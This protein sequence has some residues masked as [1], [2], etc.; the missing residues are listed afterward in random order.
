MEIL[1]FDTSVWIDF[2]KG[3]NSNEVRLLDHYFKNDFPIMLCPEI[4]L[5][6]LQ[7]LKLDSEYELM[8]SKLNR[9]K[10]LEFDPYEIAIASANLYRNLRKRGI[11]IRKNNDCV[12]ALYC[13]EAHLRIVHV[14]RDFDLIAKHSSLK[15]YS[16]SNGK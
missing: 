5:E 10:K 4:I 7:G 8:L 3:G 16:F 12:I 2:F 6:I 13:I 11:T 14:D 15:V 1:V 9:F